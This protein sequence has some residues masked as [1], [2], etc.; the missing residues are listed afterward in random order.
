MGIDED[1]IKAD[2]E[3]ND[4]VIKGLSTFN[5]EVV[6]L[7]LEHLGLT[8]DLLIA[9]LRGDATYKLDGSIL[10]ILPLYGEGPMFLELY[11]LNLSAQAN[12]MINEEGFGE[13]TEMV[14]DA[15]F[16]EIKVHLDNLLVE[17]NLET[18]STTC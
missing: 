15:D 14:L 5:I 17:E 6:H 10:G 8:L 13:I 3:V 1:L 2:I 18:L 12:V 9:D 7:D 16:T 4:L 11:N